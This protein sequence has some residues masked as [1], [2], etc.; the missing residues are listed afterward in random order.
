MYLFVLY[1]PETAARQTERTSVAFMVT[2]TVST[3]K[4][5]T[6]VFIGMDLSV[7]LD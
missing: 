7:V 6:H 4:V 2:V 3:G 5:A 1:L